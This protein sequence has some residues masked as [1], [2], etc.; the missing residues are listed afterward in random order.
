M[1]EFVRDRL[2]DP[3]DYYTNTAGLKLLGAR[4][5][6][7]KT[8]SCE[9]HGGRDSMRVWTLSGGFCCMNCGAK[10]GDLLAYHMAVH[11]MDFVSAAKALGAW[12]DDDKPSKPQRPK[13]LPA[14]DAIRIL[15]CESTLA[16]VAA[17]NLANGVPLTD[18]DRA[19]LRN[20]ARHINHIAEIFA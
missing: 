19:R 5:A 14:T 17:G 15:A 9:F 18:K 10:G 3:L 6:K 8:T 12:Q 13:P 4:N 16:A 1:G 11:G 2:P 20:S 7:V